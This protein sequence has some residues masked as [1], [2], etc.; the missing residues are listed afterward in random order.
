MENLLVK[1]MLIAALV[2]YA[3]LGMSLSRFE[4]CRSRACVQQIERHSRDIL[5]INWTPISVFPKRQN[6]FNSRKAMCP[7][8]VGCARPYVNRLRVNL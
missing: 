1:L 3:K 2:H 8:Y 5:R 7:L 4:N 6:G